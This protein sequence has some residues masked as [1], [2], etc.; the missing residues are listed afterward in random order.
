MYNVISDASCTNVFEHG[1][2]QSSQDDD[3]VHGLQDDNGGYAAADVLLEDE[4]GDVFRHLATLTE[5]LS[6]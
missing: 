6:C 5:C 1:F 3:A 4:V 2:I